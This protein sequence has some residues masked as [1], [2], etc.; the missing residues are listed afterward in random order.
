MGGPSVRDAL[1]ELR[2][3]PDR[4]A[5]R[6]AIYCRDRTSTQGFVVIHGD[7]VEE[8]GP[9]TFTAGGTT[10]PHYKVF[11]ITHGEE[12]LFEREDQTSA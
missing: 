6:G 2:W 8:V 4:D 12:V 10:I 1:N 7:E 9:S 5:S 3:H 11:R